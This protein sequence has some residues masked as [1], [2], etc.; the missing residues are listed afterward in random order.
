MFAVSYK[1]LTKM[2]FALQFAAPKRE[3]ANLFILQD[4][5]AFIKMPVRNLRAAANLPL[6]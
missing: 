1:N 5:Q 3:P 4:F 2:D 6:L